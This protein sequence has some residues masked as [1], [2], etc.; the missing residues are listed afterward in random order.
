MGLL[1]LGA[2]SRRGLGLL[3]HVP[4]AEHVARHASGLCVLFVPARAARSGDRPA[5]RR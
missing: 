2:E 5:C 3:T 4:V 1:V